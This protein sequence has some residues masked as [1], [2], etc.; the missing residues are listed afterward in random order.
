MYGIWCGGLSRMAGDAKTLGGRMFRPWRFELSPSWGKMSAFIQENARPGGLPK[1]QDPKT[2][3]S[4]TGWIDVIWRA[5]RRGPPKG[6][7]RD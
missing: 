2:L 3:R 4:D 5:P 6:Q 7:V 1:A